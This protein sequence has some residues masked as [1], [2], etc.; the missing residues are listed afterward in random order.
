MELL[1]LLLT[2]EL[3]QQTWKR[4]RKNPENIN[5]LQTKLTV[6]HGIAHRKDL[7]IVPIHKNVFECAREDG[8]V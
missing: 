8:G 1:V 6:F 3:K 2:D 5:H 7:K 4:S